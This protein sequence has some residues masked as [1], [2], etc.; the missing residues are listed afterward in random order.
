V[1]PPKPPPVSRAPKQPGRVAAVSTRKSTSSQAAAKEGL[2][3]DLRLDGFELGEGGVAEVAEAG[4]GA[5]KDGLAFFE[6]AAADAV[7]A[8]GDGVFDHGVADDDLGV[9]EGSLVHGEVLEGEVAGVDE[10]GV[11][12]VGRGDDELVHDAAGG[13]NV[14]VFGALAEEGDLG[15]GE[16]KVR[17]GEEGHGGGDFHRGRRAKAGAEGDV[18]GEVELEGGDVDVEE[19]EFAED[20]DGVVGPMAGAGGAVAARECEGLGEGVGEEG[21]S[22][23]GGGCD[24]GRGGEGDGH[25]E[26][27]AAGVVGVFAEEVD[28]GGG[29]AG[30]GVRRCGHRCVRRSPRT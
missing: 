16:G 6:F 18:A 21:V 8:G 22:V 20:A 28:A 19:L 7:L 4:I 12:G 17:E 25:G 24:G 9:G 30:D 27:E 11:A 3:G 13:V 14:V 26:D 2:G 5:A 15:G 10:E 23:V 1:Q 29:D